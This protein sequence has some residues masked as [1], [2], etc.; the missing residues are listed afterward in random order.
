[1]RKIED[2]KKDIENSKKMIAYLEE[3]HRTHWWEDKSIYFYPELFSLYA[4]L[5]EAYVSKFE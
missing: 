4:E 1:M 3:R 5:V 2:I